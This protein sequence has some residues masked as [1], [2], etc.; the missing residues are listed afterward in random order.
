M[1]SNKVFFRGSCE[2]S[3]LLL[4]NWAVGFA[5]S[6]CFALLGQGVPPSDQLGPLGY[7]C[8]IDY[9]GMKNC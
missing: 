7:V 1:E 5:S 6:A 9:K 4:F 8:C 3:T 2:G